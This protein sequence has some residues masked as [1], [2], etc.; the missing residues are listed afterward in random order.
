MARDPLPP[1]KVSNTVSM[2]TL[3]A[4]FAETATANVKLMATTMVNGTIG[5][6][7]SIIRFMGMLQGVIDTNF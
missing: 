3:K 2:E 1:P 5:G 4:F 7:G 6:F